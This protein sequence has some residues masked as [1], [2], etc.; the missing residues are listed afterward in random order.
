MDVD[1]MEY[2][3]YYFTKR[4]PYNNVMAYISDGTII[5]AA[6]LIPKNVVVGWKNTLLTYIYGVGT[7][8]SKRHS[9]FASDVLKNVIL[10]CYNREE[11]FTYLIPSGENSR[12]LYRSLGFEFVMDRYDTKPMD[13]R[14]RPSNAIVLR[15][16]E[17]HDMAR[18]SMFSSSFMPNEYKVFLKKDESYF[19]AANELCG[20]EG[21]GIDIYLKDKIIVGY[22]IRLGEEV[23][24]EV[25]D[26]DIRFL[27]SFTSSKRPFAMARI[28]NIEKTLN[29]IKIPGSGRV[30]VGVHDPVIEENNGKFA[31]FYENGIVKV[32]RTTDMPIAEVSIG[33]LTAHV[34]GYESIPQLP[35]IAKR[36]SFFINDYV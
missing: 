12:S 32:E 27:S 2:T 5:S 1:G 36:G 28:L 22:R 18:L 9:G 31:I 11:P 10:D 13:V 4:M 19:K 29:M 34:F 17:S 25:L 21:G 30:V 7:L 3:D 16:A 26:Y 23:L 15:K 35:C 20:V 33:E 14:K 24:E 8:I 6:H